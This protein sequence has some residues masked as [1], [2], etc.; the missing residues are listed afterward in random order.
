MKR[1]R[2]SYVERQVHPERVADDEG[3]PH[4]LLLVQSGYPI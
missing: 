4:P 2:L 3:E 1:R